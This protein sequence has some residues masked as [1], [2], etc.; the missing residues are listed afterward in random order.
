VSRVDPLL[1]WWAMVSDTAGAAQA[2]AER[3]LQ[4]CERTRTEIAFRSFWASLIRSA[5]ARDLASCAERFRVIFEDCARLSRE[6]K[7]DR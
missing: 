7:H 5:A 2:A 1:A 4:S 3:L 6:A